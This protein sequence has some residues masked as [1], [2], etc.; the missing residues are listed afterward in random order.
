MRLD[1][2]LLLRRPLASGLNELI[3]RLVFLSDVR[4]ISRELSDLY[5]SE[6]TE[7]LL[8]FPSLSPSRSD[9]APFCSIRLGDR[10]LEGDR[11]VEMVD[12]ESEE[13]DRDRLR[14]ALPSSRLDL[15]PRSSSFL[16]RI[17]SATPFLKDVS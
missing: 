1:L 4:F 16:A 7:R 8:R 11:F 14:E 2:D 3:R 17:S 13:Y 10:D 6:D 5:E 12:T 9:A 15:L